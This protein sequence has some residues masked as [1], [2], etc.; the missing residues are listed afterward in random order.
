MTPEELEKL[1]NLLELRREDLAELEKL[2]QEPPGG[3]NYG[4]KRTQDG[5]WV[6]LEED[7]ARAYEAQLTV[8]PE[9]PA[10]H[11]SVKPADTIRHGTLSAYNNDRCR[12]EL[13]RAAM[14]DYGRKRRASNPD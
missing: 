5:G 7:L 8:D 3:I 4:R 6:R 10:Y 9:E 14:R 13:C 2:M 11:R 1:E 12:C